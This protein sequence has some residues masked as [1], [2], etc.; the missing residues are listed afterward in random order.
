[1]ET[2]IHQLN[3][4]YCS[5]ASLLMNETKVWTQHIL[6]HIQ[7]LEKTSA[8]LMDYDMAAAQFSPLEVQIQFFCEHNSLWIVFIYSF[9]YLCTFLFMY[10]LL[11]SYS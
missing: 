2:S 4:N 3:F 11:L 8:S 5:R 10:F 9:S 6:Q 1:M 7:L